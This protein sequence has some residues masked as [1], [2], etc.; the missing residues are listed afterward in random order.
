MQ[1][2]TIMVTTTTGETIWSISVIILR[3]GM[4]FSVS[5]ARDRLVRFYNAVITERENVSPSR[6]FETRSGSIIRL[7]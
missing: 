2:K 4:R 3:T 7:W 1:A 6:S 5:S